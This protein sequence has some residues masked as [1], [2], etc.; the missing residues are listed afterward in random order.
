[1]SPTIAVSFRLPAFE[2]EHQLR[3]NFEHGGFLPKRMAIII[4][5]N[6]VGKSQ[7]LGTIAKRALKGGGLI[8]PGKRE[9]AQFNRMLAFAPT[10]EAL[11]IFPRPSRRR[12]YVRYTRYA[13]ARSSSNRRVGGLIDAIVTVARSNKAITFAERVHAY[14]PARDGIQ[15]LI[16]KVWS[17]CEANGIG[18]KT[19]TLKVKY[20]DFQQIIRSKTM[21]APLSSISEL[22]KIVSF[23]LQPISPVRKGILLLGVTLSSLERGADYR[24]RN[25]S[26]PCDT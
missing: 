23:L 9:R 5:K 11:S 1:M 16:D 17:Y 22:E 19:V 18:A 21:P 15:P 2:N 14:E 24:S 3:F 6:D 4:G 26:F 8:D 10:Q 7:A 12:Q 13:L 20:S 25:S